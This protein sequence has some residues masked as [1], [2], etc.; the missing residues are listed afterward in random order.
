MAKKS[1]ITAAGASTVKLQGTK[2]LPD[3]P[4]PLQ[5]LDH[6]GWFSKHTEGNTVMI[7]PS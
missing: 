5:L 7:W 4:V 6:D 2:A 3:I 1:V